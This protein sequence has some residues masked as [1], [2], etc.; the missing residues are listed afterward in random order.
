MANKTP[1][2]MTCPT[3]SSPRCDG[4]NHTGQHVK[5][6]GEEPCYHKQAH[7][8]NLYCRDCKPVS[9]PAMEDK[10]AREKIAKYLA[11]EFCVGFYAGGC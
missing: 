2:L 3:A 4:C 8:A 5:N 9:M 10:T 7:G 6:S 1:Q 11:I